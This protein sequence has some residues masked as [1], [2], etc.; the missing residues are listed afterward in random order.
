V[1]SRFQKRVFG[2]RAG[3]DDPD[4][5]APDDGLA[6]ALLGFGRV[7]D[8]IA[9]GNLEAGADQP[10]QVSLV[11]VRRHAAH[12]DVLAQMLAALGQR[13]VQRSRRGDGVIEEQLVEVAH[14]V[15]QQAVRVLALDRQV[16]GHHRRD[17]SSGGLGVRLAHGR[18]GM[19]GWSDAAGSLPRRCRSGAR[20]RTAVG[21]Q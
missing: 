19:L 15:E 3:G 18:I 20:N 10:R 14:A 17:G 13:D 21:A 16:L 5:I 1:A 7:F 4:H 2:Q 11:A 6:A 8:L 12:R 9:D